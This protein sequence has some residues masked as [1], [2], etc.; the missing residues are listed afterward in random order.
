MIL[1]TILPSMAAALRREDGVLLVAMQT[2]TSSGDAS[3]DIASRIIDSLELGPKEVLEISDLPEPG[4]RLQDILDI[5]AFGDMELHEEPSFWMTPEE[6]SQ[7][8]NADALASSRDQLIPTTALK[9]VPHAY[10]CRMSREFLR[11]VRSEEKDAVLDGLARLRV[12]GVTFDNARFVGAFRAQG[13]SIPVW[14]LEAGTEADELEKPVTEFAPLLEAAIAST[15]PL[16]AEEKRARAGIVSR[17]V[18]LR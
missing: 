12:Q 7:P 2:M 18:T 13:L 10:W 16:T 4:P 1:S 3:R 17:Q 5:D 11:W 6:A 15:E 9:A 8:D 14:E